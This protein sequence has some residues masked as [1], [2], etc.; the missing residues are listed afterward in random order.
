MSST[1]FGLMAEFQTAEIPLEDLCEKYFG[2]STKEAHQRANM[3]RLPVPTYRGGSQ[4][5]KRL[6][7]AGVLAEYLDN[8]K[9]IADEEWKKFNNEA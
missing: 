6:V 3:N 5:S 7:S 9:K 1:Y 8:K 4:K 2:L